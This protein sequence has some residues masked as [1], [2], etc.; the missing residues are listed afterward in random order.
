VPLCAEG[1]AQA[2]RLRG[3]LTADVFDKI[4]ASDRK[5][6]LE[7]AR[8]VFAKKKIIRDKGLREINFGVFEGLNH[9]QIS[10]RYPRIYRNWLRNP[11]KYSIP[12]G[13]RLNDF[14][15]RVRG[16]LRGIVAC[17]KGKCVAVVCHGGAISMLVTRLLKK[18]DFW[19]RVPDSTSVTIIEYKKNKASLELFNCTRH[20]K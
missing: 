7:T 17:N 11:F 20:L 4:Y 19:G 5:R 1:R 6:A 18:K 13:E 16:A 3:R 12:R 10:L 14:S 2:R 15:A 9:N 8:I